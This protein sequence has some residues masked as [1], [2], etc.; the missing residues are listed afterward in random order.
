MASIDGKQ[1][2]GLKIEDLLKK[3]KELS[4]V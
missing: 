4:W 3:A 2:F 1:E